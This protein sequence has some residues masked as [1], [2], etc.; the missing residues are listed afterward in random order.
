MQAALDHVAF[1]NAVGKV[2]EAVGATRLGRIEGSIDIVHGDELI[3]E[4]EALD[5]AGRN[6]CY[7]ADGNRIFCHDLTECAAEHAARA[8]A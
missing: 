7:G 2:G 4:L 5:G 8:C 6:V 1:Q 3:A